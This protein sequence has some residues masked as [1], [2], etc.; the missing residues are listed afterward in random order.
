MGPQAASPDWRPTGS[1]KALAARA[2]LVAR[3]RQFFAERNVLEVE[4]PMLVNTAVSDPHLHSLGVPAQRHA[5]AQTMYLHTSPEYA[6]KRLLAAGSGDIYQL[7]KVFRAGER[8]VYHNP[9]FSLLEWYRLDISLEQLMAEVAALVGALLALPND[10][11]G[12]VAAA[13]ANPPPRPI[14][15]LTYQEAMQRYAGL[16]PLTGELGVLQA[17]A[18]EHGLTEG[19]IPDSSRDALLDFLVSSR[20]GPRLGQGRL[21]F[22]HRYPRSQAALAR[23]DPLDERLALR[24]ELYVDGVELANGFHELADAA[25]QR[26]RFHADNLERERLG[27][28][29]TP[30]DE[31]LLAALEHGM[32]DCCGVALG[33]DRTLMVAL[34][35][36]HIDDV[37]SFPVERA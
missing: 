6:M 33:L 1:R 10:P 12:G 18:R 13:V 9:E 26:A 27:L 7:C 34:G 36:D 16:D 15:Y 23:L 30:V 3:A 31:H 32:P 37:L 8:G 14:E 24:F 20:V 17:A 25:E 2:R 35:V 19:S 4:T 21:T 22:L 5:V 29:P 11:A 28:P